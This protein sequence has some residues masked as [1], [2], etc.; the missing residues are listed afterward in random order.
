MYTLDRSRLYSAGVA[1]V[2]VSAKGPEEVPF[3]KVSAREFAAPLRAAG[4]YVVQALLD[5]V[6]LTG[7]LFH[8]FDSPRR[9]RWPNLIVASTPFHSTCSSWIEGG[10]T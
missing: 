7:H 4:T 2:E 10:L 6:S 3:E 5:G 8:L 9:N 1:L